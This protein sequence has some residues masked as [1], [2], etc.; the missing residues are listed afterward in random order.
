MLVALF[1]WRTAFA[2]GPQATPSIFAPASTPA[3]SIYQLSL[4]VLSIT[5]AI[6]VVVAGLLA[7]AIFRF[8]QRGDDDTSEPAQIYGSVQVEL[9]WTV[10][11]VLIVVVLFLTTARMI[12][13]I[14]DAPKPKSALDVTVVGHQFWWEFNYPKLGLHAVNELHVPLSNPQSPTPTFLDRKST[15]LNS[16]HRIASRMPSSA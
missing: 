12:F 11:P 9:A 2:E 7:Y 3:T 6:F 14:Q 8:R 13:A 16:S 5:G 10:I 15:R 1:A 4:F